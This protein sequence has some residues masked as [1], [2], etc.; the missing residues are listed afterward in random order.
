MMMTQVVLLHSLSI[1]LAAQFIFGKR[2][3]WTDSH[4]AP[5]AYLDSQLRV[6]LPGSTLL[7]T[8]SEASYGWLI[9]RRLFVVKCR[10]MACA[11]EKRAILRSN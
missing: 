4:E 3:R 8:C 11:R 7:D 10:D 6:T 5:Y 2:I 9:N 1:V